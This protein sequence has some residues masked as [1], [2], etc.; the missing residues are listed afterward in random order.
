MTAVAAKIGDARTIAWLKGV[1]EQRRATTC[2]P[3]NETLVTE[4]NSGRVEVGVINHY[5]WYRMRDELGAYKVHSAEKLFAPRDP[6][7]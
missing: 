7:T 3:D 4:V 5:Y 2:I 6:A 1:E